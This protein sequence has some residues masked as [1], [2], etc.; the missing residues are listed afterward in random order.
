MK[1][2]ILIFENVLLAIQIVVYIFMLLNTII[3]VAFDC[4]I[5]KNDVVDFLETQLIITLF[6]FFFSI[7]F[8]VLFSKFLKLKLTYKG[9]DLL[10]ELSKISKVL[11]LL[12]LIIFIAFSLSF[13]LHYYFIIT[14]LV[15]HF[16]I[17]YH[18]AFLSHIKKL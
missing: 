10:S 12:S 9:P 2:S 15:W 17:L 3:L 8:I 14:I 5:S 16:S 18:I 13:K 1:K 11:A 4:S 6:L 7:F